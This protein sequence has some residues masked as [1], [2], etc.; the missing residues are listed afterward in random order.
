MSATAPFL[1]FGDGLRVVPFVRG[2]LAYVQELRRAVQHARGASLAVELPRALEGPIRRTVQT[3]PTVRLVAWRGRDGKGLFVATDPA[4]AAIEAVRLAMETAIPLALLDDLGGTTHDPAPAVLP[5]PEA[6]A[7]LGL[8]A[9]AVPALHALMAAG[10]PSPRDWRIARRVLAAHA[11][12]GE[13]GII[14]VVT[15]PVAAALRR[16]RVDGATPRLDSAEPEPE[17]QVVTL[18]GSLLGMVMSE[19]P[20]LVTRWEAHRNAFPMEAFPVRRAIEDLLHEAAEQYHQERQRRINLMERRALRQFAR[21]LAL[22]RGG[23]LPNFEELVTA[24]KGCVD[25]D[26]GHIVFKRALAYPPN[27]EP[28][29]ETEPGIPPVLHDLLF[30]TRTKREET[31]TYKPRHR[32][33]SLYA[34]FADGRVRV[35]PAYPDGTVRELT[36]T[37]RRRPSRQQQRED[38]LRLQLSGMMDRSGICSWPPE[39]FRLESFLRHVQ[40]RAMA[41]V[42]EE[43]ISHSEFTTSTEEGLDLRETLRGRARGRRAVMVRR[44]V[45]PPGRVGPVLVL[46]EDTPVG[47]RGL[48]A[49]TL[50]AEHQNESDIAVVCQRDPRR[51]TVGPG[52]TRLRYNSILAFFPPGGTPDIMA[53]RKFLRQW[54]TY[55]RALVAAG[56]LL[57]KERYFAV[58]SLRPPD[59]E[60]M[61]L[62]RDHRVG[63]VHLPLKAFSPARLDRTRTVHILANRSVRRW[64]DGYIDL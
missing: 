18:E 38:W 63:I 37:F 12:S 27:A 51:G 36:F 56:I 43:H 20:D 4:D 49:A 11:A 14:A 24:A 33:L 39:D 42:R 8:E 30:G 28:Q 60:L 48:W 50:Y 7:T 15:F 58:V 59:R 23:L 1:D 21:N 44:R 5:D 64:A 26:Y 35:E 54:G 41:T 40:R 16:A 22:L 2:R 45:P 17:S 47:A 19:M 13:G 32:S 62:A 29:E 34:D 46:W 55:G 3:L 52:I 6:I 25:D 31:V 53:D 57:S 10:E 61:A 9:F